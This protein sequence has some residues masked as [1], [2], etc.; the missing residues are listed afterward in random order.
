M[1]ETR[2]AHVLEFLETKPHTCSRCY[3]TA[4]DGAGPRHLLLHLCDGMHTSDP[5]ETTS[6]S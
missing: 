5:C 3:V 4:R 6:Y 1:H 2:D